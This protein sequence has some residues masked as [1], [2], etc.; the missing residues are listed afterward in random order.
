MLINMNAVNQQLIYT[1][2]FKRNKTG[3]FKKGMDYN[4]EKVVSEKYFW[5]FFFV[6][7]LVLG[8]VHFLL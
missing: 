4:F 3:F 6:L 1:F 5:I 2:L 8:E 7:N